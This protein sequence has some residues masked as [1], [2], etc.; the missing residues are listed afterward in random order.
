MIRRPPRST[1]SRSSAASDVYKRQVRQ[2]GEFTQASLGPNS[3]SW[4]FPVHRTPARDHCLRSGDT[5]P[6]IPTGLCHPAQRDTG[7]EGETASGSRGAGL[8]EP[9]SHVP[10][11]GTHSLPRA[12][13]QG[14][15]CTLTVCV[16]LYSNEQ[17]PQGAMR[18][19]GG[20]FNVQANKQAPKVRIH[21]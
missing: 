8:L 10:K 18:I 16:R 14:Q 19:W 13:L 2:P 7:A 4:P 15:L 9:S 12:P 21:Q 20:S 11:S 6:V 1:Q 5:S 17:C 3:S